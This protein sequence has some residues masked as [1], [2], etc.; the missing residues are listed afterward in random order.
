MANFEAVDD[1]I[2][3]PYPLLLGLL[4]LV[5]NLAMLV[6]A[7]VPSLTKELRVFYVNWDRSIDRGTNGF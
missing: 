6:V 3:G 4:R 2:F 7:I 1:P 5:H